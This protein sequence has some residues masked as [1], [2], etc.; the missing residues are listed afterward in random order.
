MLP[1]GTGSPQEAS[2]RSTRQAPLGIA[3]NQPYAVRHLH[4][5]FGLVGGQV[6]GIDAIPAIDGTAWQKATAAKGSRLW[7]ATNLRL[8][9]AR[10]HS[11]GE[12][13][14]S[15]TSVERASVRCKAPSDQSKQRLLQEV[16]PPTEMPRSA[17]SREPVRT[18]APFPILR[19]IILPSITVV[20]HSAR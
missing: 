20:N 7:R 9:P 19:P 12:L 17:S 13:V 8:S 5:S 11:S 18:A 4:R 1:G 6:P 10:R 2:P 16:R 3:S 14:T 15:V